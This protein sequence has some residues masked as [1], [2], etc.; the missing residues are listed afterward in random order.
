MRAVP[1]W[2]LGDKGN[3][4]INILEQWNLLIR[5][6]GATK[7]KFQGIKVAVADLGEESPPTT[8]TTSL[9]ADRASKR[10]PLPQ[11]SSPC[12]VQG[13]DPPLKGIRYPR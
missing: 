4:A 5:N 13:Q 12:F 7:I 9:K 6:Q 8:T 1:P 2:G 11:H 3:F 10:N